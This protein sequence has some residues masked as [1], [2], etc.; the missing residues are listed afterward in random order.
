MSDEYQKE[1]F[2]VRSVNVVKLTSLVDCEIILA[3]CDFSLGLIDRQLSDACFGD[4]S[5]RVDAINA[6][7][8]IEHKRGLVEMKLAAVKARLA[9]EQ[10]KDPVTPE[11]NFRSRFVKA[12]EALLAPDVYEKIR[13]A[14]SFKEAA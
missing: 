14:A 5:W 13:E 9:K 2:D 3:E 7:E 10:A 12:A 8:C 6:R 4:N 1:L 11:T